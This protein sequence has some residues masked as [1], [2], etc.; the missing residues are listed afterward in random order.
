MSNPKMLS[1]SD[2]FSQLKRVIIGLGS[3]YLADREKAASAIQQF[4]MLPETVHK[5]EVLDLT[6]PTEEL[7]VQEY[8]NFISVLEKHD[9]EVL[10]PDPQA[11]YSFDYTCPRDIGFVVGSTFFVSTMAV[12]SRTEEY[13]TILHHLK[14]ADVDV[15]FC[16]A[17]SRSKGETWSFGT[18]PQFWLVSTIGPTV[19]VSLFFDTNSRAKVS[20]YSILN[21]NV[22]I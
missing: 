12:Q 6:Y 9:V 18:N 8:D 17:K 10:R 15:V 11:A 22:Y 16:P 7:L 13:K 21:M 19:L 2:K 5:K 1:I 3:P 4:T 20:A 14:H